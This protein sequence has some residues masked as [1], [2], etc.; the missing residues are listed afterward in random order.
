MSIADPSSQTQGKIDPNIALFVCRCGAR[1][2]DYHVVRAAFME[3]R[4]APGNRTPSLD[5]GFWGCATAL[6]S[7]AVLDPTRSLTNNCF[8]AAQLDNVRSR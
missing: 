8:Q 2:L 7:E 3:R 4:A 5:D 1:L 6:T